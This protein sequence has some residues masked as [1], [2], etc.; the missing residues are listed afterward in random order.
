MDASGAVTVVAGNGASGYIGDGFDATRA[1]L[2]APSGI[3]VSPTGDV[4]IADKWN[5]RVRKVDTTGVITTVAG[6]GLV[7]YAGD[8]G[9][10]TAA[11]LSYPADVALD[12]ARNLF[13]ADSKNHVVRR[14]DAVTGVITTVAGTGQTGF[15]GDGGPAT[16]AKLKQP[17]SVTVDPTGAVLIADTMNSR[18]RRVD[19][20]TGTI[21]TIAGTGQAGFS[22]DGGAATAAKLSTPG[23]VSAT[24]IGIV[25][26]DTGN[27]RVRL[28]DPRARSRR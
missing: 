12:T 28:V 27:N 18:L 24:P 8:G 6:I 17:V 14:V 1:E 19:P 20:F 5:F 15:S 16:A 23:G 2:Y 22:G 13:I 7:G 4:Y 10:A 11:Q 3:A 21:T 26:A 25:I 9:P